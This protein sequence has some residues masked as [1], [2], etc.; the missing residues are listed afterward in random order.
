M[1]KGVFIK[2]QLRRYRCRKEHM[3]MCSVSL[4]SLEKLSTFWRFR[5]QQYMIK[6]RFCEQD[7][8][9]FH[10]LSLC[11]VTKHYPIGSLH[12]RNWDF[13]VYWKIKSNSLKHIT[14]WSLSLPF[15]IFGCDKIIVQIISV[16]LQ[17]TKGPR[18]FIKRSMNHYLAVHYASSST[19]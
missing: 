3:T 2:I 16:L 8:H 6:C 4:R 11:V 1:S 12:S 13:V 10:C 19:T 17:G 9:V 18:F 7:E 14:V 5:T 15:V